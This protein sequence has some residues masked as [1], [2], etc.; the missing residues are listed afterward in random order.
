MRGSKDDKQVE[1][2]EGSID[3]PTSIDAPS[4]CN[5]THLPHNQSFKEEIGFSRD[6]WLLKRR[7][8]NVL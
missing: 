4:T 3:E 2:E 6:L 8:F 1:Q 7:D 5:I